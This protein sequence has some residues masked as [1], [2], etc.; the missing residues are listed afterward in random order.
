MLKRDVQ[1]NFMAFVFP[2][3]LVAIPPPPF[4]QTLW[5]FFF[6][7]N[8]RPD[9]YACG[10]PKCWRVVQKKDLV[11]INPRPKAVE[12]RPPSVLDPPILFV[13]KMWTSQLKCSFL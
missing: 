4:P 8:S 3:N 2:R 12:P 5:C 10:R 6:I 9:R 11:S 13:K 1:R 7:I